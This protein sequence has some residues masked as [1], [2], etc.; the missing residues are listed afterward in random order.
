MNASYA[1]FCQSEPQH[2]L[3]NR[4]YYLLQRPKVL[5]RSSPILHCHNAVT[6]SSFASPCCPKYQRRTILA[7]QA[8]RNKIIGPTSSQQAQPRIRPVIDAGL[9]VCLTRFCS[10]KHRGIHQRQSHN[11][12]PLSIAGVNHG[13]K[14]E[15]ALDANLARPI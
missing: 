5:L 8:G 3:V 7:G 15:P 4:S 2:M 11:S 1:L 9:R 10:R 6:T 13:T 12:V 14:I